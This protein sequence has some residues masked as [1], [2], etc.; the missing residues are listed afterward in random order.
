[1]NRRLALLA[2]GLFALGCGSKPAG[3]SHLT[4]YNSREQLG[5]LSEGWFSA[6][7][8]LKRPPAKPEEL[9]RI[10]SM[11]RQAIAKGE[12]VVTWKV[13]LG[14]E[15]GNAIVAY[16]KDAPTNGGWVML[17]DGSLKQLSAGDF[18]SAPKATG[19]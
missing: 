4:G 3:T 7:L 10:A 1:M 17:Q 18:K 14:P 6:Q 8:T 2:L 9:P 13:W 16:E 12:V 19:G 15:K 11:A 5:E